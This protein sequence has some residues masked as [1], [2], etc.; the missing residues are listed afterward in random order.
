MNINN[1]S[2][3]FLRHFSNKQYLQV[4]IET[5]TEYTHVHVVYGFI[6]TKKYPDISLFI[7]HYIYLSLIFDSLR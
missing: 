6:N 5:L 2:N 7:Y 1:F 4:V 3:E